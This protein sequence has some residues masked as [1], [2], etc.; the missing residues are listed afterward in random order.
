VSE[1][2]A[3]D[4]GSGD[5]PEQG[6]ADKGGKAS[7]AAAEMVGVSARSIETAK[8][9][10]KSNPALFEEVKA[11]KKK[12]SA[13]AK[14]LKAEKPRKQPLKL[15]EQLKGRTFDVIHGDLG[16]MKK[17]LSGVELEC[18]LDEASQPGSVLLVTVAHDE[19]PPAS[20][21]AYKFK[22]ALVLKLSKKLLIQALGISVN[23][24]LLAI[25]ANEKTAMPKM[26]G[27]V[28][29][30]IATISFINSRFGKAT[31]L[32]LAGDNAPDD[33]TVVPAPESKS[34]KGGKVNKPGK[35]AKAGK[36]NKPRSQQDH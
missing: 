13:A 36:V 26:D 30:A 23:H 34:E 24:C 12:L 8:A 31:K 15:L 29:G 10:K 19:I 18:V 20:F 11:G 6:E 27:S 25:Y 33:W 1:A 35:V 9:L 21:G 2:S 22:T 14:T 3:P 4:D 32:L 5:E 28:M 7:E 17:K 16:Q